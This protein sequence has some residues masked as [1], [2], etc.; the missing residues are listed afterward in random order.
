MALVKSNSVGNATIVTSQAVSFA[1]GSAAAGNT[2]VSFLAI[3]KSAGAAPTVTEAGWTVAHA[4]VAAD[5]SLAAAYKVAAGGE[6]TVTWNWT[7]GEE[8]G[9]WLGEDD[10]D[11]FDATNNANS[12]GV[13][14]ASQVTGSVTPAAAGTAYGA[15]AVDTGFN[16]GTANWTTLTKIVDINPSAGAGAPGL[17]V[18][19]AAASSGVAIEGTAARGSG[20]TDDQAAGVLVVV[21]DT[22]GGTGHTQTV[23]DLVGVAD[24]PTVQGWFR[25][26]GHYRIT[27][28]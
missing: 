23:T 25:A 15:V 19:S 28:G 4:H 8:C 26:V 18:A 20:A 6:T 22:A 16:W 17:Y 21:S 9:A 12:G 14:V 24:V 13:A 5:V 10:G 2:L 3:D 1:S 27:A 11:A 7:T